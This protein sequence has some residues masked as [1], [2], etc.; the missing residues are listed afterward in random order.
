LRSIHGTVPQAGTC[1]IDFAQARQ[2]LR[3]LGD[4]RGI[5]WNGRGRTLQV[6]RRLAHL[7]LGEGHACEKHVRASV[8]RMQC[9]QRFERRGRLVQAS[10]ENLLLAKVP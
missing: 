2:A 4:K 9:Q 8:A 7:A 6:F 3:D 10:L 1:G 5:V